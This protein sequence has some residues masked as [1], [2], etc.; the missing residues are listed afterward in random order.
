VRVVT[1]DLS[2]TGKLI[3]AA[4]QAGANSVSS[5]S[6]GLQDP[7]PLVLQA[8]AQATKQALAHAN[9]IAAGLGGKIASVISAQE[10]SSYAPTLGL[11]APTAAT[12]PVV[13]GTVTV[14][15]SVTV[16]AALQ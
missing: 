7:E 16:L 6:F 11:G 15:A 9:S 13:S 14:S 1:L 12:T 10:G 8:L 4:N 3:D 5:L 2:I